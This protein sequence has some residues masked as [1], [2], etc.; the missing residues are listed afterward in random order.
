MWQLQEAK[1]KF[2][3]VV[4]CAQQD[5]PQEVSVHGSPKVVVLSVQ[6]Y[7]ALKD[8]GKSLYDVFCN[9]P[10]QDINNELDETV[11]NRQSFDRDIGSFE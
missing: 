2:S 4:R 5:G 9:S 10:L 3:E 7:Q 1:A 11:A 6:D 8:H